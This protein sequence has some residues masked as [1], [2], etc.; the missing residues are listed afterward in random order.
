MS[1]HPYSARPWARHYLP[2]WPLDLDPR[3]ATLLDAFADA[4]RLAPGDVA[5][6]YFG[7]TTTYA[8]LDELS[9]RLAG[10]M[11]GH[12]VGAGDRIAIVLQNVPAFPIAAIAA[13]KLGAIPVPGNPMYKEDELARIFIDSGPALL[14]CHPDHAAVGRAAL[15]RAG[16]E[17]VSILT[18]GAGDRAGPR[19]PQAISAFDGVGEHPRLEDV[20]A[21][22][23]EPFSRISPSGDDIGL[24]LYTSGTTGV[25]KAAMLR[26]SSIAFNGQA[27]GQWCEVGER[28]RI[29]GVAPLFHIT[30]FVSHFALAIVARA[31]L[32]LH[33][34]FEPQMVLET[35]RHERPTFTV[36]AITAFNAL[37]ALDGARP[38]DFSSFRR[39]YSGGAAIAPGL[40]NVIEARLGVTIHNCYGMTETS[41]PTHA[42][43]PGAAIPVDPE[44][45]ALSIGIPTFS[46]E[47][48]VVDEHGSPVSPGSLGEI[49]M[50][51]PQVMAGYWNKPEESAAALHDGWMRSGDVG[52]MDEDGWFYL[53]DRQKDMINASGFK[54]WPRE[55][56]DVLHLHE[57]VR[58]AAVVGT[59]DAYRGE[60]VLAVVSLRPGGAIEADALVAHCRE[61]LAAYKCPRKVLIM[62]EL[63]K[64]PT[65]KIQRNLL[66]EAATQN[67]S[68]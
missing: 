32:I 20:L 34:R 22:A 46:T 48:R 8:E 9:D 57:A 37:L 56:E 35:I 47:A 68:S 65:G 36:G 41:S 44:S 33:F 42:C 60:T 59:P 14:L 24:M 51:G 43:P 64:T 67:L 15:D 26:H 38:E 52:F 28:G 25:P 10:W 19:A 6:S 45:G 62:D 1:H 66:R 2:G 49:W 29:L 30:G 58:E 39:V 63:P 16:L 54:V 21:Q 3:S 40:R 7:A 18:V 50:R 53:V 11:G 12:G 61:R 4:I 23:P 55:V 5:L 13:W 27:M 31:A 17:A